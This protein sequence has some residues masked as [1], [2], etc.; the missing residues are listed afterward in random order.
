MKEIFLKDED[1]TAKLG[2]KIGSLLFPG[3][4]I[5]LNGDLGAGKTTITKSIALSLGIDEDITSPTFTIVNEY[6]DYENILYHFDVYRIG[7]SDEMYDIGFD[8]YMDSDGIKII[9]WSDII[10]DILPENRLDIRLRY[11]I[12]GRTAIVSG[13][14][15]EY[16]KIEEAL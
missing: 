3:A 14:G 1:M 5:C 11:E 8:D 9:E 12:E 4:L 16:K 6:T 10:D 2:S 7:S 13:L 15:E